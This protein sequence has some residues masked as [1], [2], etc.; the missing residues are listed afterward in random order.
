M[1]TPFVL[2]RAGSCQLG[3]TWQVGGSTRAKPILYSPSPERGS[4]KGNL[5]KG[6][7]KVTE[8]LLS[9]RFLCRIPLFRIPLRRTVNFYERVSFPRARGKSP[10]SSTPGALDTVRLPPGAKRA[11]AQDPA[12]PRAY[13]DPPERPA[14]GDPAAGS[15]KFSLEK[16]PSPREV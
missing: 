12:D 10:G 5:E 1:T 8:K 3:M 4:K 15:Q 9:K 11:R 13:G 6:S 14:Y 2:T 16:W 7:V